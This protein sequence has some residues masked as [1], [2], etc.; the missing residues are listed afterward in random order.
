MRG[1]RLWGTVQSCI[2]G[3]K[4]GQCE[5]D[6]IQ[7]RP[8]ILWSLGWLA[9]TWVLRSRIQS[10]L[11][12]WMLCSWVLGGSVLVLEV[13]VS[14][15]TGSQYFKSQYSEW[16]SP[17]WLSGTVLGC[18]VTVHEWH[19]PWLLSHS[20]WVAQSLVAESQYMS[21]TVLGGWVTIQLVAQSLVAEWHSPWWL[22]HNT[23]GGQA[24]W[25]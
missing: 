16:R 7:V 19:S 6:R 5:V 15:M 21:G 18:W 11:S 13:P 22:S 1:L 4:Q 2:A 24:L 23:M 25:V 8:G 9:P 14:Y 12:S 17:W 10:S 20:T 3:R